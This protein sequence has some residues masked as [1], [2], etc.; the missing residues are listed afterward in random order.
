MYLT[1]SVWDIAKGGPDRAQS[2]PNVECALPDIYSKRIFKYS[3]K[4]IKGLDS[5]IPT[6]NSGYAS[7]PRGFIWHC[8]KY[9]LPIQ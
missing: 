8:V 3:I 4:A 7:I 5:A 9:L 6:R 1:L 2:H